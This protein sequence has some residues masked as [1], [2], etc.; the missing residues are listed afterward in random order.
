MRDPGNPAYSARDL[1]SAL[2][3]RLA[4]VAQQQVALVPTFPW[5]ALVI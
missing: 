5:E 4:D 2:G 3:I 1:I